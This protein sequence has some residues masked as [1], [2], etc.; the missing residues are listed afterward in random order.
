MQRF[1]P[2]VTVATVIKRDDRFLL[3]EELIDGE[4]RLNQPAGHI[5]HGETLAQAAIRETLEE[6]GWEVKLLGIAGLDLQEGEN[7][8]SYFRTSFIAEPLRHTDA[9]L[10]TGI[11][12][13]VW[14]CWDEIQARH[15]QWRSPLVGTSIE[16]FESGSCYPLELVGSTPTA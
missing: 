13:A 4:L 10:D 11:V 2:H 16:R 5:E 1:L 7:G 12:A 3:V 14:L 8:I 6:T 9:P 15:D